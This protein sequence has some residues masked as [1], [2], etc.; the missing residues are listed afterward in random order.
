[1]RSPHLGQPHASC[2]PPC[3]LR[4]APSP[5][6]SPSLSPQ[7][8]AAPAPSGTHRASTCA[9]ILTPASGP[10]A[11]N[12]D[13]AC[14]RVGRGRISWIQRAGRVGI[15]RRPNSWDPSDDLRAVTSHLPPAH[16]ALAITGHRTA[17]G[18]TASP[19]PSQVRSSAPLRD[20]RSRCRVLLPAGGEGC[21]LPASRH[22]ERM[23]LTTVRGSA[24]AAG[25]DR[26]GP[27]LPAS[28]PTLPASGPTLP[29]SGPT[30]P[31]SRP[32][33]PESSLIPSMGCN[34]MRRT[35][36]ETRTLDASNCQCSV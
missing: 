6:P 19:L 27:T 20:S 8:R 24:G 35:G 10:Q 23:C 29:A 30:L 7:A 16:L 5:V 14:Q 25:D 17:Q 34:S 4:S 26:P 3:A 33:L 13:T 2:G 12:V 18:C 32:A 28:G 31:E 36:A 11:A 22:H 21:D 9:D 1:M 15:G